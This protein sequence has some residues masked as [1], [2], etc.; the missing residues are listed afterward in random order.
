MTRPNR[1]LA[2]AALML[3]A[4]IGASPA[5][6]YAA[7]A[8]KIGHPWSRATPAGA[9]VAGGYLTITNTG[10]EPDRLTAAAL[11]GASRGEIHSM[12]MEGNVMKM[13][14]VTGGLEIKPGETVTLKPGGYHLMFLD[15]KAPLKKGEPAKGTVTFERAGTVPVEFTVEGI[16]AQ[17]PAGA[18]H[19]HAH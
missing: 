11:D 2:L 10:R 13:A 14:P 3:A 1:T 5:H 7:G 9:K 6:D 17:A 4:T 15:L 16:G 19:Q 18:G 8:L 12:T